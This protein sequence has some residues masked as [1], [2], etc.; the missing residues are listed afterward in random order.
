M[1]MTN[2]KSWILIVIFC[3]M[4]VISSNAQA[5]ISSV[6]GVNLGDSESTVTSKISGTWNT[7]SKGIRFYKKSNPT[8]GDCNFD[9]VTFSF[10]NGKLSSV[11]FSSGDGGTMDPNF[12]GAYGA[13]NGY[14]QFLSKSERY[15]RIY[16]T[17]YSNLADKYGSPLI[18]DED[19]A[20]WKSNGNMIELKYTFDDDTNQY[21]WHDGWTSILVKYSV[22]SSSSNF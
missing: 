18:N 9:Q 14:E 13:P 21:G 2:L 10:T 15:Q 4:G 22:A 16:R 1:N 3:A 6:Y 8:L 12:Q 5:R 17:M 7:T 11:A 20:V 19:R